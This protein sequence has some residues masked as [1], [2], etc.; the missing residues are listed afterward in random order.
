MKLDSWHKFSGQRPI[1]YLRSNSVGDNM[2][3]S[4]TAGSLDYDFRYRDRWSI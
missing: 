1:P 4:F 3:I 2:E